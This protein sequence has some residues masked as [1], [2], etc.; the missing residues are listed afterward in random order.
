MNMKENNNSIPTFSIITAT[1]NRA[2]LLPRAIK[3]ILTQTFKDFELIIIDDGS[4]DNTKEVIESFNDERIT[5]KRLSQNRGCNSARN[6]GLDLAKGTY[7]TF[8]DSDDVLLA[9]ALGIFERIWGEL[10]DEKIGNIVTRTIDSKTGKKIGYL[11]KSN[12]VLSYEDIICR[13]KARGEFR[14][15]WKKN[16]IGK[17]RFEEDV[18]SLESIMWWRLAKNYDFLYKDIP[19]TVYYTGSDLSLSEI[20]SQIRNA[21]KW[22]KGIEILIM[23]HSETWKRCCLKRYTQYLT[24]AALFNLLAG[25]NKKARY[26]A[27]ITLK[28]NLLSLKSFLLILLSFVPLNI[29]VILIKLSKKIKIIYLKYF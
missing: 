20:D 29:A 13:Q 9:N 24:G 8:A 21:S 16:A 18:V 3:S 12:L 1:Y 19:T 15:C 5:Y 10:K 4:T 27:I 25:N 7:I 28:Y 6:Y 26:W 11:E 14:S 2:D 17:M 23:E 22:A